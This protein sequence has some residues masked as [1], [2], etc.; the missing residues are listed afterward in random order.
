MPPQEG[1]PIVK[2]AEAECPDSLTRPS[3]LAS[4]TGTSGEGAGK[5]G[6]GANQNLV[7][8]YSQYQVV[9]SSHES[10]VLTLVGTSSASTGETRQD[11][12]T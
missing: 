2:V 8:V 6:L 3:F 9:H 11:R 12:Q 7:A 4:Y 10:V 1:V 5:L